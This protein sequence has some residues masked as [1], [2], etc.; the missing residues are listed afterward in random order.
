MTENFT[1]IRFEAYLD[2]SW[3][4]IT[5]D[6][7]HNP[8]PQWSKGVLGNGIADRVSNP[9]RLT[10]NLDN[11]ADNSGGTAGWYTPSHVNHRAFWAPG[12]NVRLSFGYN[13]VV[14]YK[15]YGEIPPNG[16]KTNTGVYSTRDVQVTVEDFFAYLSRNK[17]QNMAA[18]S[19]PTIG[20]ALAAIYTNIGRAPLNTI[21]PA[22]T[23]CDTVFDNQSSGV[24]ALG[25]IQKLAQSYGQFT[26]VMCNGNNTDGETVWVQER[27]GDAAAV[28]SAGTAIFDNCY[29]NNN[30]QVS[31]GKN[32]I[33]R[34][35]LSYSQS[36]V[37]G[38]AT[39]VM[40]STK[41]H[42]K[43]PAGG[44]VTLLGKYRD[45]AAGKSDICGEAMVAPVA[46]TDY[47]ANDAG[48][49]SG[50]DRTANLSVTAVFG[51]ASVKL[52]LVN[53]YYTSI[54]VTKLQ[55]RGKGIYN[56]DSMPEQFDDVTGQARYGIVEANF[57]RPYY[58]VDNAL[59]HLETQTLW[60][61]NNVI[62]NTIDSATYLA[63]RNPLMMVCFMALEPGQSAVF[64]ESVH[65]MNN[66]FYI[67]GY[68]AEIVDMKYVI[69]TLTC[70]E[71][72]TLWA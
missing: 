53:S 45:P 40:W 71:P 56:Y 23:I 26:Y 4:D 55:C 25:E 58:S 6:V 17:L 62:Y 9:G 72:L 14:N 8:H 37:D 49:G 11:T 60:H 19:V 33:N 54:Y 29:Q 36:S 51:T 24:T 43:I 68:S 31:Y 21:T 48:D 34:L 42:F 67:N 57:E 1:F 27:S 64:K 38:S 52:T 41:K 69:W 3:E 50:T 20:T 18:L 22:G 63:N 35:T 13:G 10:F 59:M 28:L 70:G 5:A 46:T 61:M 15:F 7:R 39:T 12:I 66:T 16:I 47:K 30:F 32:Y 65:G 44:T 2:G